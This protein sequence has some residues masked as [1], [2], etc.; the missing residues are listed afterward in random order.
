MAEKRVSQG[1]LLMQPLALLL[2][3]SSSLD[4]HL[5]CCWLYAGAGEVMA[6]M[7]EANKQSALQANGNV[8]AAAGL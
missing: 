2:E 3:W 1:L 5:D 4:S 8:P 7:L 6:A